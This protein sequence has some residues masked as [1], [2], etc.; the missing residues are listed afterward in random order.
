[1]F[2]ESGKATFQFE[3]FKRSEC[4]VLQYMH[5]ISQLIEKYE[6]NRAKTLWIF[7]ILK[8]KPDNL[9]FSL[10]GTEYKFFAQYFLPFQ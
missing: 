3:L 2:F 10:F 7:L 1:M 5:K 6:W 4:K 9:T 8:L